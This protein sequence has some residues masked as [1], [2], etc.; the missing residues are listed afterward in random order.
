MSSPDRGTTTHSYLDRT[1]SFTAPARNQGGLAFQRCRQANKRLVAPRRRH[2]ADVRIARG[3]PIGWVLSAHD[4]G[5]ACRWLRRRTLGQSPRP[6][7]A[8]PEVRGMGAL[9]ADVELWRCR[10]LVGHVETVQWQATSWPDSNKA[11]A[12]VD[13]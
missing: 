13:R 8:C 1:S 9:F 3:W 4:P 11:A 5:L 10:A 12:S 2:N 6:N 7:R